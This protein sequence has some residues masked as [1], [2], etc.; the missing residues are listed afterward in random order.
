MARRGM[1]GFAALLGIQSK[2]DPTSLHAALIRQVEFYLSEKNMERD[3]FL[4][5]HIDSDQCNLDKLLLE[6]TDSFQ[7]FK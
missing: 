3:S 4:K 7:M 5:T 6:L 1:A 2:T